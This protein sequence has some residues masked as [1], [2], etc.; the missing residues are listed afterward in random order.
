M[1]RYM[2]TKS[3]EEWESIYREK[4]SLYETYAN[5]LTDLLNN[6]LKNHN[7]NIS[8]IDSRT[9]GIESFINKINKKEKEYKDPL[10]E[11]TDLV[12][13]RIITY[14]IEDVYKIG[15]LVKNEF[16][17]DLANSVDKSEVLDP[18]KFGYLSNHYIISLKE[19]RGKLTEWKNFKNLKAEIQVRTILQHAWA[20]IDHKLRYKTIIEIPN[21]LKRK[22]FR[23]SA[24][25]ELADE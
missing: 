8:Q 20:A 16:N 14:Y 18:D 10:I 11:I 21:N 13:I 6:I 19:S 12:G 4:Y 24:I 25:L 2:E 17:I 1:C 7:I 5:K 23:L 15:K 22:L 3:L 9:K